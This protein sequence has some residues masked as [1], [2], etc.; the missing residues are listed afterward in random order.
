MQIIQSRR[1]FLAGL[2]AAGAAAAV[3][4]GTSL[5]DEAPLEGRTR[6]QAGIWNSLKSIG[7]GVLALLAVVVITEPHAAEI[8][9]AARNGDIETLRSLLAQAKK[10]IRRAV[11]AHHST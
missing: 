11:T 3:G 4:S 6:P 2:S 10:S 1:D 8:H 5:A 7:L 9:T